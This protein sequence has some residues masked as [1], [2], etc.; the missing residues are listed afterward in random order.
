MKHAQKKRC[1]CGLIALAT[2]PTSPSPM[3]SLPHLMPRIRKQPTPLNS[4]SV[5]SL[6]FHQNQGRMDPSGKGTD[7]HPTTSIKGPQLSSPLHSC[8]PQKCAGTLR[9]V[10]SPVVYRAVPLRMHAPLQ[11]PSPQLTHTRPQT[12]HLKSEHNPVAHRTAHHQPNSH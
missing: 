7:S 1:R 9:I 6:G 2:P 5:Q 3:N 10:H 11:T 4:G 8:T 12:P